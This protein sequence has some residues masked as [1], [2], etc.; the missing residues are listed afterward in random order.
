LGGKDHAREMPYVTE[1][2]Y[3]REE[4]EALAAAWR[5]GRTPPCPRC[6]VALL[7]KPVQDPAA[8]SYVRRR[9]WLHCPRCGTALVADDPRGSR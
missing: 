2:T 6:G 8:V 3:S 5:A 1:T 4:R 7:R 9:S